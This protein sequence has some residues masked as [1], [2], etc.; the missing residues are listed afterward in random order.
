MKL[1]SLLPKRLIHL[2]CNSP[3]VHVAVNAGAVRVRAPGRSGKPGR[4]II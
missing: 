1:F 4:R 3:H 2:A